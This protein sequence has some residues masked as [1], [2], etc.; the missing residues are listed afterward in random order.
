M[1]LTY[2]ND[3]DFFDMIGLSHVECDGNGMTIVKWNWVY[4]I[5]L[6]STRDEI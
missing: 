2:T 5:G 6:Y 4:L 3:S 1:N